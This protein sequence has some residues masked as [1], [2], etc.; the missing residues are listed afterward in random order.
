M[1]VDEIYIHYLNG[2]S[3]GGG[4]GGGRG[5]AAPHKTIR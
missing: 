4:G 2:R 1:P 3:R 5:G